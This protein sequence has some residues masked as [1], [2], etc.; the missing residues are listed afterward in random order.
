M[1][2]QDACSELNAVGFYILGDISISL[3]PRSCMD[4]IEARINDA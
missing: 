2:A 4:E 1:R 3:S